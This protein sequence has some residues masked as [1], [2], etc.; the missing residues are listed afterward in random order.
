MLGTTIQHRKRLFRIPCRN[1]DMSDFGASQTYQDISGIC[2]QRGRRQLLVPP[3]VR[4]ELQTTPYPAYTQYQLDMRRKAEIF[5]YADPST[6]LTA[7]KKYA[8]I[9]N[10]AYNRS[11]SQE[12]LQQIVEGRTVCPTSQSMVPTPTSS[13]D[14][15]GPPGILF[16]D[17]AIPLY[18]FV[19][20]QEAGSFSAEE[21]KR[22][23]I[24]FAAN[25]IQ[26]SQSSLQIVWTLYVDNSIPTPLST[27]SFQLPFLITNTR[28]VPTPISITRA[29]VYSFYNSTVLSTNDEGQLYTNGMNPY[30]PDIP[31]VSFVLTPIDGYSSTC[32]LIVSNFKMPTTPGDIID[33][34]V[35]LTTNLETAYTSILA[36]PTGGSGLVFQLR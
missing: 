26:M 22:E 17:P 9:V 30:L 18:N 14:V 7:N 15:P 27:I 12:V 10:G 23:Y 29:F 25:D 31:T 24:T 21:N 3:N 6:G 20:V 1:I 13:C 33:I 4:A 8:N 32:L 19:P 2:L 36:N 16:L 28:F 11:Y 34:A 35:V 5:R